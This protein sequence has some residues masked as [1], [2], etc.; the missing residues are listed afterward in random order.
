MDREG[1]LNADC[2]DSR[3]K[4]RRAERW[5]R[6]VMALGATVP[7]AMWDIKATFDVAF[8]NVRGEL[9]RG[10]KLPKKGSSGRRR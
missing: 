8:E 6:Q 3:A 4:L 9:I 2:G 10:K 7:E 1:F 5:I